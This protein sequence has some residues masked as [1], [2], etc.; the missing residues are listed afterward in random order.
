MKHRQYRCLEPRLHGQSAR[1][2]SASVVALLLVCLGLQNIRAG[3]LSS[4]S[5]SGASIGVTINVTGTGFD[6]AAANN[7]VVFTATATSPVAV[8][9]TAAVLLDGRSEERRVGKECRSWG[10]RYDE[11]RRECR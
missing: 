6:A 10:G 4:V 5:P 2:R 11:K 9:P 7:D 1:A 3:P 8:R